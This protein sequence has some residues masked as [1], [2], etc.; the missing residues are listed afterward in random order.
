MKINDY[1][2]NSYYLDNDKTIREV[3]YQYFSYYI[4]NNLYTLEYIDE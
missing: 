4:K 2:L 1:K 3:L